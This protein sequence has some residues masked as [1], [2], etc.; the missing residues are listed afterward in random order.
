MKTYSFPEELR[1][2]CVTAD[3]FPQGV[4]MAFQRLHSS[5]PDPEGRRLFGLSWPDGKGGMLYKAAAEERYPGEA[6]KVGAEPY[7]LQKGEYVGVEVRNFMDDIPSIG[8][9]FKELVDAPGV[10][11]RT[12]GIEEYIGTS[13]HCMV[14]VTQ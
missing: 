8:K 11:P 7:T 5:V 3:S 6:E 2:C 1:L 9:A 10:D 14:P 12:M 13:V 4:A